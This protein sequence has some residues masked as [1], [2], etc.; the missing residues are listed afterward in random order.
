[1]LLWTHRDEIDIGKAG[2]YN[3]PAF[4]LRKNMSENVKKNRKEILKLE[5]R[6]Q[7][8]PSP[9]VVI[10]LAEKY[11][12]VGESHQSVAVLLEGIPLFPDNIDIQVLCA[13]YMLLFQTDDISRAESLIK[14]VLTDQP[15]NKMGQQ[16]L[17]QIHSQVDTMYEVARQTDT[18]EL[19]AQQTMRML[20]GKQSGSL[21]KFHV[22]LTDGYRLLRSGDLESALE[23]FQRILYDEPDNTDAQEGFRL[24]YAAE[25]ESLENE[26]QNVKFQDKI[27]VVRRT[28]DFLE[29]MKT[30]AVKKHKHGK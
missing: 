23:I 26:R 4:L 6:M 8:K 1:M 29:A 7:K 18:S 3:V 13:K 22:Q 28:I 20:K 10:S 30:V 16:L 5:K 15:D 12:D 14:K 9:K 25:L 11:I 21:S 2:A 24:A 19:I 27:Q 17:E